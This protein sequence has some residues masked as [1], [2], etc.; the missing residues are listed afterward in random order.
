MAR[1]GLRG[2]KVISNQLGADGLEIIFLISDPL[3]TDY[4]MAAPWFSNAANAALATG[5]GC[6]LKKI[7][8]DVD[9]VYLPTEP[10]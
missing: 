4:W 5:L 10:F 3:I 9:P 1:P 8:R 6:F 7:R 2:H